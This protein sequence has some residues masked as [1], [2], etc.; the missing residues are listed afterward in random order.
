MRGI[1][2]HQS[3]TATLQ[4]DSR[5]ARNLALKMQSRKASALNWGRG[6]E[7]SVNCQG[8]TQGACIFW[9][10]IKAMAR[11]MGFMDARGSENAFG[12]MKI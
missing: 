9:K 3:P 11:D 8:L 2:I 12:E 10:T 6:S 7:R 5:T 1:N 4:I